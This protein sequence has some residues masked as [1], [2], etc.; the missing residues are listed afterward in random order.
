MHLLRLLVLSAVLALCAGTADAAPIST[1]L[2]LQNGLNGY[3]GTT[4]TWLAATAVRDNYGGAA[5]LRIRWNSGRDD[6]ALLKFEL[7]GKVPAG[8]SILG[9]TLSLYFLTA[10]GFQADNAVTIRAYRL[11]DGAS[12]DENV[13]NGQFGVGASYRYRDAAETAEWTGGAEG[14]WWDKVDDGNG[15][16]KIKRADGTPP[17]AV[18]PLNW[19]SFDVAPSVTRWRMG[20]SNNGFLLVATASQG[21][22]TSCDGTFISRNDNRLPYRPRLT[23]VYEAPVSA[24]LQTWGRIK[25][26]YR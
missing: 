19:V 6:C 12:W 2:T 9:A 5:D 16:A 7:T 22:G 10:T 25:E 4:D 26:L 18:P 1:T 13:Y 17:D 11:L 24:A 20:E 8:A 3:T 23:I 14:G 15:T 21:S